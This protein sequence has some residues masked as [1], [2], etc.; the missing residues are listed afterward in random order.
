MPFGIW[1]FE[2]SSEVCTRRQID[3]A[4]C[5]SCTFG[6]LGNQTETASRGYLFLIS[7]KRFAALLSGR[8]SGV[9]M[10][11]I[12]SECSILQLWVNLDPI[13]S[14]YLSGLQSGTQ[15]MRRG[16]W[17]AEWDHL[18]CVLYSGNSM[19]NDSFHQLAAWYPLL[20]QNIQQ[21]A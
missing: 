20:I 4:R 7:V 3:F 11:F 12:H 9:F 19:Q 10:L 2:H 8:I 1:S 18:L 5:K 15:N 6:T 13:C 14:A 17:F 16:I 21:Y